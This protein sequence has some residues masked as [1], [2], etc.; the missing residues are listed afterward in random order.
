MRQQ[1]RLSDVPQSVKSFLSYL[2]N[3]KGKSEKTVQEYYYDLRTFFR[4][5]LCVRGRASFDEFD[6][7]D[8]SVVD[9]A[10]I[11]SITLDDL[12]EFLLFAN[13]DRANHAN[14]RARKV[15]SLRSYFN[16]MTAKAHLLDINITKELESPKLPSKLPVY[17]T[18]E[19]SKRLLDCIEGE[20]AVRD[21]AI[22]T[23]FLNCGMRLS[24]LVG[25]D[26]SDVKEDRITVTGKGDKQRTIYLNEACSNA[27]RA[28]MALRPHDG[29]K[30]RRALFLSK[31]KTRISANMVYKMVQKNLLRAGLDPHKYSP[32]KL[33]HTAATLM[34]QHGKVD[35]R[36]LQ[37]IL[38][39][40]QLSTTQIYTHINES[41]LRDAIGKNPLAHT[42]KHEGKS[43]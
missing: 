12:Y 32:H 11:Q 3:I 22:I 30:D 40:E 14:A 17:L 18:L 23:L 34:Y 42:T 15:S 28:Y 16:Y 39:H 25:I 37:E 6:T 13:K 2:T 4:F 24:E 20:F 29:V 38:G 36:A 31:Q 8:A 35:V 27:L 5:I 43:E 21:Y 10:M 9:L 33:R 19:E 7:I 26:L 41:Q 1:D